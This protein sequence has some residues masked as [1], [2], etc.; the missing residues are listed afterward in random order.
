MGAGERARAALGDDV[1]G[2][3]EDRHRSCDPVQVLPHVEA[4]LV[5][6]H[7]RHIAGHLDH[8]IAARDRTGDAG[9]RLEAVLETYAL[10]SHGNHDA[11]L[12]AFLHRHA[13]VPRARQQVRD[14]I[15]DLL[16][17]AARTGQVRDDVAPDELASY[18]IHAL[19]AAGDRPSKPAVRRLVMVTLAGLRP[20]R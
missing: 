20:P 10:L 8:L 5:A 17:E 2:R 4:I 9:E 14:I 12:A 1:A 15:R 13:H 7:E 18:S 6:W 3:R 11:Q 19:A 16:T